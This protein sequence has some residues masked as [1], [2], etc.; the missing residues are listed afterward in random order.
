MDSESRPRAPPQVHA[1]GNDPKAPGTQLSIAKKAEPPPKAKRPFPRPLRYRNAP[2][3][4][5]TTGSVHLRP[6]APVD[7]LTSTPINP[8][9][10]TLTT[11]LSPS[12][13]S[14]DSSSTNNNKSILYHNQLRKVLARSRF[15]GSPF[16]EMSIRSWQPYCSTF[17]R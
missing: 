17:S 5:G 7:L 13:P 16:Q 12:Y 3:M 14:R 1:G 15:V 4:I 11:P 8:A 9:H 2:P 6:E 10:L